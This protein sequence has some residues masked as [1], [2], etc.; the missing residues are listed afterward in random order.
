MEFDRQRRDEL[1]GRLA[2]AFGAKRNQPA[3]GGGDLQLDDPRVGF[4][5]GG[6][7]EAISALAG[8]LS[9][10]G[11]NRGF[12]YEGGEVGK[13]GWSRKGQYSSNSTEKGEPAYVGGVEA[14]RRHYGFAM[15]RTRRKD[16]FSGMF[17]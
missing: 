4:E 7:G 5:H 6:G 8:V 11:R 3:M 13:G 15:A 2:G 9:S 17:S 16:L 10:K 14:A 12:A 1:V